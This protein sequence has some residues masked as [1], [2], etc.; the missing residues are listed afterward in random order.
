[1][2]YLPNAFPD[3]L[4]FSRIIRF[5]TI[6]GQPTSNFFSAVYGSSKASIHPFLTAGLNNLA[7]LAD[8]EA[9]DLLYQQTLAPVFMNCLPVY[10]ARLYKALLSNNNSTAT[11]TSQ[12]S[13]VREREPLTLKYCPLCVKS[14][15]RE[16]GVS[17]WHRSHQI[18]GIESCSK[19]LAWL[20]HVGLPGR[21]RTNV[22]LPNSY[23]YTVKSSVLSKKL[24]QYA[25]RF[26][27]EG[28]SH[29]PQTDFGFYSKKLQ[30]L[31]YVT[32]ANRVRRW[33]LS[34][35]FYRF[36]L[37][38][39]YPSDNLLPKKEDDYKYL[40]YLLCENASQHPFKHI[41]F[42]YWLEECA[43]Q[44]KCSSE[45]M[46]NPFR[47][48]SDTKKRECLELLR[49]GNSIASISRDIGKS[50]CF[51]KAVALR[52]QVKTRL[53]P[54]KL[55]DLVFKTV[56]ELATRGFNRKEIA[57]RLSISTGSVE[58]FISAID[59]LVQHRKRC[60]YESKRRRY[61]L[62]ILRYRQHFPQT[63]RRDIKRDC[64]AAFFWLYLHE[65][66]WLE[67]NLPSAL[68]PCSNPKSK[69]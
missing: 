54:S 60:K 67:D 30:E 35:E 61:Q 14:D 16:Y 62:E 64:N 27:T 22:G 11:R 13:C 38:L 66:G 5:L 1:M 31:G 8:E 23:S 2:F 3:E 63:I 6:S 7:E 15:I 20:I 29:C 10:A 24:A 17:Y 34:N 43:V 51:V 37:Q 58:M 25:N 57:R 28:A 48:S 42:S 18:P 47:D 41:L 33:L 69:S 26:L 53:N 59:G 4:L 56:V 46:L 65:K 68:P 12:L 21:L 39:N 44:S 52:A 40:S 19:H 45:I 50:R 55:T 49:K 32:R 9:D 36:T